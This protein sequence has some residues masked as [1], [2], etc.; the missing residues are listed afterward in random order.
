MLK[1]E[2]VDLNFD[3]ILSEKPKLPV[4]Y[5]AETWGKLK[6]AVQAIHKSHAIKSSLE[7]LY[8]VRISSI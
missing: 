6:E 3:C 4:N 1:I 7:E 2:I 8:Q 5:Q